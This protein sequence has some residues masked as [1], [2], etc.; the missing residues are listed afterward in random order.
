M[1]DYAKQ[2]YERGYNV[3]LLDLRG[4]GKSEGNYIGMGW[5]DRL[6][7]IDWINYLIEKN[8]KSKILLFGISMGGATT[9]MTT[10]EELPENVKLAIA[11]CGYTS[12]W[13]EFRYQ[14]KQIYRLPEF[15]ALYAADSIC[16][17]KNNFS[18]KE[19]S[20]IKQLKK[21][22]TPTLFIHGSEDTY[23]PFKMLD[24]VYEAASC[25]KEK[26]V[27]KNA[28]H[29]MSRNTNPELYWNTIDNFI[30]KYL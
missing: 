9:M 14:L 17:I 16:K 19:A 28:G 8:S 27:I 10:G 5:Y 30:K 4:H 1:I 20:A 13:D 12:V 22:K 18:F 25:P 15:P 26:L 29:C 6:D 2:F 3:L 21:S 23:V 7:V 24:I 11:D